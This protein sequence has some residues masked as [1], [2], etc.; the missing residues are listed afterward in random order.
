MSFSYMKKLNTQKIKKDF[1]IFK[2]I[3]KIVYLDSAASS[4]TPSVVLDEMNQYYTG[5]RANIHRGIYELSQK[6]TDAYENARKDVARFIGA[7]KKEIIFTSGATHSSNMIAGMLCDFL[8]L[9][10]GD[11][12]V[13]TVMEHHSNL[14][15]LRRIAEKTGAKIRYININ[16]K[17]E[18]D[19]KEAKKII[20]Q[21]TKI[22]SITVASNVLG[23]VNNI[24]RIADISHRYKAFV[25]ADATEAVGHIPIN[26]S[27]LDCDFLFF[28]A[29]KMCGPTGI[30]ALYGKQELLEKLN[31]LF[32]GGGTVIK[33]NKEEIFYKPVPEKFEAGTPNIAGAIGF[34]AAARYLEKIG[35]KN[36]HSHIDNVTSYAINK[37][38]KI[39]S[40]NI[41]TGKQKEKNSGI[42]SF[43]LDG[44]HSHDISQ[45]LSDKNIAVRAGH[46]CAMILGE[47]LGV[48]STTRASFYIYNTKKDVDKLVNGIKD[49][50][51]IF[52]K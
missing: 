52:K 19:Y 31:P 28:S 4:Q 1:V 38:S 42:I 32:V 16:N 44:I 23:T 47:Q 26:V 25:I 40:I 21:K 33:V 39:S 50:Q 5:Y 24:R 2:N 6:A 7:D 35:I 45:I 15:P 20:T 8:K 34:G 22:V 48:S 51:K 27:A 18:L 17:D 11:E 3:Q 36:I 13:T 30:G 43:T 9:K 29:H 14:L 12:I 41:Y 49:I 10:K 37:L 46:H